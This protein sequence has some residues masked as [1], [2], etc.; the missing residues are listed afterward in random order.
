MHTPEKPLICPACEGR[1]E[2][3]ADLQNAQALTKGNIMICG[4][5]GTICKIGDSDLMIRVTKEELDALDAQSKGAIALGVAGVMHR[6]A[7]EKAR[8]NGKR[9]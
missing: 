3:V 4:L 1:I 6:L 5:C 2:A 7:Q 9:R 8:G